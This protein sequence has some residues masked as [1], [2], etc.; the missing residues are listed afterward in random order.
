MSLKQEAIDHI[1]V[2][3]GA[4]PESMHMAGSKALAVE[5][6]SLFTRELLREALAEAMFYYDEKASVP[7]CLIACVVTGA[8]RRRLHV[9]QQ[10]KK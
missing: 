1:H 3:Q 10:I 8:H 5:L 6:C 9:M 4:V 2:L 7:Q